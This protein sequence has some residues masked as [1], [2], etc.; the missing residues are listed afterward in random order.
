M[1]LQK[2]RFP[3]GENGMYLFGVGCGDGEYPAADAEFFVLLRDMACI[4][5]QVAA[6]G[7]HL[8][9]FELDAYL[10]EFLELGTAG[11]FEAPL[12]EGADIGFLGGVVLVVDIADDDFEQI[13]DGG[14]AGRSAVFVH[15]D[16]EVV[17][18][19]AEFLKECRIRYP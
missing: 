1:A 4:D 15:H 8:V 2:L 14:K 19:G 12:V 16:G 13:L 10:V 17:L 6:D 18:L 5:A 11:K 9:G 7:I 3:L